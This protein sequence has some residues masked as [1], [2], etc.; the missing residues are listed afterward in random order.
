MKLVVDKASL[1]SVADAIREKGG[2]SESL[3]FPQ[4]FVNAV[5]AI[6]SGGGGTEEIENIID[7]S[8]VLDSTD[9]TATD[10]VEQ[11]V[12][13]AEDE[14]LWYSYS[15]FLT[16]M[17]KWANIQ[18]E[19]LPRMNL[20]NINSLSYVFSEMSNLKRVDFY[21]NTEKCTN[22]SSTFQKCQSLKYIKGIDTAKALTVHD[23][24]VNC[25]AL[26]TIEEP[27]DFSSITS[28]GIKPFTNCNALKN[29]RFVPETTKKST[30]IP[31]PVLSDESKDSIINGLAYVTT[32]QTLTVSKNAGF[33]AE[34][35]A[36]AQSK[37]WTV[38]EQ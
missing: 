6:E 1:V 18:T 17:T 2:T 27:L 37:G 23:M 13:K 8:G 21:L 5:G 38:V 16:S 30:T 10:K 14:N 28:G 20:K 31:S 19:R 15:K 22:F 26:E 35:K 29:I 4:G 9:G 32:A 24:F 7:E 36:T 12:E 11:L 25:I 34:H 3:E 33:T